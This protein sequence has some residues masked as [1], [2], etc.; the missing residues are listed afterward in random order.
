MNFIRKGKWLVFLLL[1]G[2]LIQKGWA[3]GKTQVFTGEGVA[4]IVN[5]NVLAA[6]GEAIKKARLN[7]LERAVEEILPFEVIEEKREAIE[8]VLSSNLRTYIIGTKVIKEERED[9]LYKVIVR[10]TVDLDALKRTIIDKGFMPK[11]GL[12]YR[13]RIMVVI[14]E[15]HF[16]RKIPDPAAETEIIRQFAKERF[17]V[18]DQKQVK[19]NSI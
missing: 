13:P 2:L 9:G 6:R 5:E 4:P 18:V 7:A 10:A 19:K 1:L 3:G 15:Q 12:G 16:R 17:Y 14:P 8:A 11:R